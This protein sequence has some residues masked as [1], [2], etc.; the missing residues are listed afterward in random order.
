[1]LIS[2]SRPAE[3]R[4][5]EWTFIV[6]SGLT[7]LKLVPNEVAASGEL[8]AVA[9]MVPASGVNVDVFDRRGVI[10]ILRGVCHELVQITQ[11]IDVHLCPVHL[12]SV[13][14]VLR[15]LEWVQKSLV[16][17]IRRR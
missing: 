9:S 7:L 15:E 14:R 5:A 16:V 4:I 2:S 6:G 12:Q 1:M 10:S 3:I 17:S 8:F 11:I 13:D